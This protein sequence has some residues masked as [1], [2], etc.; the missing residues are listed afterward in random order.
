MNT[1]V[2]E[3]VVEFLHLLIVASQSLGRTGRQ[4]RRR[5]IILSYL[6]YQNPPHLTRNAG[7]LNQQARLS[8][9]FPYNFK[10]NIFHYVPHAGGRLFPPAERAAKTSP[11][12]AWHSEFKGDISGEKFPLD[13]LGPKEYFLAGCYPS[14]S[15]VNPST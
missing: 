8:P 12:P 7:N 1:V 13:R 9:F 10:V 5:S 4:R 11:A 3:E 15:L 14:D 2:E 6:H